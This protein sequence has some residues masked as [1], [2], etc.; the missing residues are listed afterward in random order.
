MNRARKASVS[1][2]SD[3]I[4]DEMPGFLAILTCPSENADATTLDLYAKANIAALKRRH[5]AR[6]KHAR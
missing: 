4:F 6:N 5:K 2:A 3:R 1:P